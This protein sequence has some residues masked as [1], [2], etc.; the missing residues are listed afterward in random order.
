MLRKFILF[1]LA[2]TLLYS[3]QINNLEN[4]YKLQAIKAYFNPTLIKDINEKYC[5]NN[6]I[7]ACINNIDNLKD[8]LKYEN[9]YLQHCKN[10]AQNCVYYSLILKK[11]IL[12]Y[13][14]NAILNYNKK[15]LKKAQEE[16]D[17]LS[18]ISYRK[19][20]ENIYSSYLNILNAMNKINI[21]EKKEKRLILAIKSAKNCVNFFNN[22]KNN[23]INLFEQ[24]LAYSFLQ[25]LSSDI[26][27]KIF[28]PNE[29]YQRLKIHHNNYLEKENFFINLLSE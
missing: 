27:N 6:I 5:K 1:Y 7:Q 2:T 22:D 12:L 16:F 18:T 19:C 8:L 9:E 17:K 26:F 29:N 23:K 4:E 24:Y 20:D 28:M 3:A 25:K 21:K 15:D 14:H 13:C 11:K 10:N